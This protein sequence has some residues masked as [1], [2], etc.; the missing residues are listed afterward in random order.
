[1]VKKKAS[2]RRT[3]RTHNATFKARVALA[4]L[5][6]DKTLAELCELFELHPTQIT[7]WKRQLLDRAAEV[8]DAG[9]RSEPVNLAP[10]HAKIGQLA[11]END[12]LESA[13]TKA[14]AFGNCVSAKP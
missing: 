12:F 7:E 11:L 9:A 14:G 2:A 10:L 1:M 5:R 3:R 13:L 8:F 6:E 4:A